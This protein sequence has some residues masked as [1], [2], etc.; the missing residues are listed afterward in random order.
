VNTHER[1]ISFLPA[2]EY[3]YPG[4]T[5]RENIILAGILKNNNNKIDKHTWE[6]INYFEINEW[7]DKNFKHCSTGIKKRAQLIISLIGDV[8]TILWDEPN[9]GL[10]IISNIKLKT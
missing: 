9:D 7:L 4:L 8:K 3:L 1:Y 10:D 5:C 6:L 2:D